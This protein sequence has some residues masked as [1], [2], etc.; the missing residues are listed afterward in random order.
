M[1]PTSLR[2]AI[3]LFLLAFGVRALTAPRML[4]GGVH[5]RDPDGWYHLRRILYSI[6]NFPAALTTDPY[7]AWPTG[8]KPIWPPVFDWLPIPPGSVPSCLLPPVEP[9]P[10]GPSAPSPPSSFP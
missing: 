4:A 3:G 1:R 10:P 9:G 7:V 8:A 5:L 6:E 2:T